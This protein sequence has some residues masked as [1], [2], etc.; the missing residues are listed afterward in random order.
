MVAL[1]EGVARFS[2]PHRPMIA[3]ERGEEWSCDTLTPRFSIADGERFLEISFMISATSS[4][5]KD[6]GPEM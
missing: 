4:M 2:P 1:I 5:L 6:E 3:T